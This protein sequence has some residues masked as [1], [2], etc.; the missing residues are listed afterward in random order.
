MSAVGATCC[1]R[2][3]DVV[4]RTTQTRFPSRSAALRIGE[5]FTT[6]TRCCASKYSEENATRSFRSQ[7]MVIVLA[8]MST[9]DS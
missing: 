7:V 6:R 9:I 2:V 8:T 5:P 4:P 3:S 1:N